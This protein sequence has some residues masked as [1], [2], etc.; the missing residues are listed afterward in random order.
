MSD[1]LDERRLL[2]SFSTEQIETAIGDAL[3]ALTGGKF[4]ANISR[5]DF[6]PKNQGVFADAVEFSIHVER[7]ALISA[8]E[9]PSSEKS[10]V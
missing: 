3:S 9:E 4:E 1:W 2:K 10:S 7:D 8:A 6:C 5:L